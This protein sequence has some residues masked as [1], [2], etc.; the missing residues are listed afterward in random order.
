MFFCQ[1]GICFHGNLKDSG[2]SSRKPWA[3]IGFAV[4]NVT[5]PRHVWTTGPGLSLERNS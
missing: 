5:G 2:V 3:W 1:A 4:G